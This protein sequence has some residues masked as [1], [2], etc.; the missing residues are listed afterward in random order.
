MDGILGLGPQLFF[1]ENEEKKLTIEPSK[2]PDS[3]SLMQYL[4]EQKLLNET[5]ACFSL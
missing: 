2:S 3:A 5:I 4:K 1:V